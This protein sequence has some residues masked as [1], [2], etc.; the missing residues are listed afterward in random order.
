MIY[1]NEIEINILLRN[2]I[3]LKAYTAKHFVNQIISFNFVKNYPSQQASIFSSRHKRKVCTYQN[4]PNLTSSLPVVY[5]TK[6][7]A[8]RRVLS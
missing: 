3:N 4:H 1:F 7:E 2:T 6:Q 5:S 8:A